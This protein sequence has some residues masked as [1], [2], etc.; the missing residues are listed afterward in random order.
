MN[1]LLSA[2]YQLPL[3]H[4]RT[5]A[6]THSLALLLTH[7]LPHP[8][9]QSRALPPVHEA[10]A[11]GPIPAAPHARTHLPRREAQPFRGNRKP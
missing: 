8:L 6:L 11:L 2:L 3:T 7:S 5:H 9:A 10:V 1:L 4:A